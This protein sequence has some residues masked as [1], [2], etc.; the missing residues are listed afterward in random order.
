MGRKTQSDLR[1]LTA[2]RSPCDPGLVQQ[3]RRTPTT[4]FSLVVLASL[5]APATAVSAAKS[6]AA[7][8]AKQQRL[9]T[10]VERTTRRTDKLARR[11]T[12]R[13]DARVA[14][15]AARAERRRKVSTQVAG[16]VITAPPTAPTSRTTSVVLD[17]AR[18]QSMLDQWTRGRAD[19]SSMNVTVRSGG[20][21][22]SGSSAN[23]GASPPDPFV[24]FRVLS[25]TKT[26]TA[27]LVLRAVESGRLS[28]DGPLPAID[29]VG[30]ALPAGLT[31]RH[32]LSHQSGFVDYSAAPGYVRTEP[33][34]ARSAIELTLRA[35]PASPPG[36]ITSYANSNYL[37]LGLL[38]EQVEGRP[39][40]EL[41][42][43]MTGALGLTNTRVEP[44]D[45]PGWPAFSSGGVVSTTADVAAWGES[46]L[47]GGNVLSAASLA[48][49]RS[50]NGDRA[51]LGLWGYC[52]CS[53]VTGE[54]T[55]GAIGHH[56]ASGGLFAFEADGFVL[57]MR[58]G[59]DGGD[60]TERAM[61]LATALRQTL[62]R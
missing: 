12:A 19:V 24:H 14:A 37:Y 46:L 23:G 10:R 6:G 32:L 8:A 9:A 59:T 20:R 33:L 42:A 41:V 31:I 57:V 61:S 34:T 38:L 2:T 45:R 17:P 50:F 29:G 11:A 56:T 4:L 16:V 36:T 18:L 39:Y 35:G 28:L 48:E 1:L 44:P 3:R 21:S 7:L 58:S 5:L 43:S 15:Q 30:V 27:A 62:G 22:W 49:M 26:I 55:F 51:G 54:K 13:V 25:V 47:Q 40:S 52:P 60:T 53:N